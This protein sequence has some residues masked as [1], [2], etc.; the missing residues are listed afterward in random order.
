M[1]TFNILISDPLSEEGIFPLREAKDF[2]VTIKTDLSNEELLEI[3]EKLE[4]I[5]SLN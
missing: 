1:M 2:N 4:P 3:L 5:N